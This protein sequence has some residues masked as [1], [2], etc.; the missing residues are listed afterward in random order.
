MCIQ[1]ENRITGYRYWFNNN[2]SEAKH[3]SL[4]Q[5]AEIVFQNFIDASELSDGVNVITLQFVDDSLKYSVPVNAL[6][7]KARAGSSS[8]SLI[9][10]YRYWFDNDSIATTVNI[11]PAKSAI[12]TA[13]LNPDNSP[14]GVNIL[15]FQTID[16]K[17][18]WSAPVTVFISGR[19]NKSISKYQY[20]FN[21]NTGNIF[22]IETEKNCMLDLDLALDADSLNDGMNI[23]SISF[24]DDLDSWSTPVHQFFLILKTAENDAH[25]KNVQYWFDNDISNAKTVITTE[26][27]E[28]VWLGKIDAD[29]MSIGLHR[30]NVRFM[31]NRGYWSQALST[32]FHKP[33]NEKYNSI[34]V[35]NIRY[36]VDKDFALLVTKS[37]SEMYSAVSFSDNIDLLNFRGKD[38]PL[39]VQFSDTR[40]LWSVPVSDSVFVPVNVGFVPVND[41][42]GEGSLH[43]FPNPNKGEFTVSAGL[44]LRSALLKI[45]D[46]TGRV[47]YLQTGALHSETTLKPEN[48][49]CGIYFV[50]LKDLHNNA[51]ILISKMIV[52]E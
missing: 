46:L 8:N 9:T 42:S 19:E 24:A 36:W 31:D 38:A 4:T 13:Q 25:I 22:T 7:Y 5:S 14:A 33:T 23:L 11:S 48:L 44:E 28:I 1:A 41:F 21:N 3:Q 50:S 51:P 35:N 37:I 18:L 6:F 27:S 30:I 16:E 15:R 34:G 2:I 32:F 39:Y 29:N 47:C 45:T 49:K 43:I 52:A 40:G 12:I 10:G 20:W 26:K 17:N